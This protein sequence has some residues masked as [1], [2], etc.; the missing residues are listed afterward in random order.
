PSSP[1]LSAAVA[2]A[3][4][5]SAARNRHPRGDRKVSTAVAGTSAAKNTTAAHSTRRT[6]CAMIVFWYQVE[7][8]VASAIAASTSGAPMFSDGKCAAPNQIGTRKNS[9]FLYSTTTANGA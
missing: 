1:P 6:G 2:N 7:K 9:T 5:S 3:V 8:H 4:A